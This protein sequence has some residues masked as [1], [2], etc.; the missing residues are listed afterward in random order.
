MSDHILV[1]P[2]GD[3]KRRRHAHSL[4]V[5]NSRTRGELPTAEEYKRSLRQ[6]QPQPPP[7]PFSR[8]FRRTA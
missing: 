1:K 3:P 5:L 7:G 8:L 2:E 6:Q 4:C